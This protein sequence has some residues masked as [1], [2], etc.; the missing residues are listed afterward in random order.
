MD[1]VTRWLLGIV[2]IAL[3][4]GLLVIPTARAGDIG[5][6]EDFALARDRTTA[7]K[8]L[9]PGTE[10]YYYYHCLHYLNTEQYE[11]IDPLIGPWHQRHSQTARL[12]EIQTRLALLTYEK[13]PQKTLDYLRNRLGLRFDHQKETVGA[14]PDL[15]TV[16]D[17]KLISRETLKGSSLARW[18]NLDNFE[19][20][21]LDWMAAEKLGW[22]QMRNLISRLQRPDVADLPKLIAADLKAP[23][24]GEFGS[25]PIHA[26]LTLAQLDEVRKLKPD[27]LNQGAYVRTYITKLQPGADDDWKRDRKLTEAY[28]DRLEK[29]VDQLAPVHNA[30]K[31]HVLYHRLAFDRA[32]GV[33]DSARFLAY[34]Q[35][36]RFQPYMARAWNERPESGRHPADLNADF[37]S[38]TLLPI[39]GSDEPL[40]RTYLKHFFL[41]AASTKEYEPYIDDTYLRYLFAETKIETGQ[42]EPETWASG[43]PPELFRQ[44]KDRIDIDFAFTNKTDFTADEAVKLDLFIKNVPTLLVKVFEI[45]TRNL[46]RAHL[47][48]VDTD[49]NLDGLVANTE[50]VVK[51]DD[52]PFRRQARQFDFPELNKAGT[53][54]IDFIGGGKSSRALIRKGRLHSIVTTGI[55]GQ[56][57]RVIDERHRQVNDASVWLSGQEYKADKDGSITIPF[58]AEP[59]QR[60]IVI[61]RG[62]F[63][64][65]DH[66]AHQPE[67]Y[68][69]SAG[70][71]VDR[72]SLLTQRIAPVL[73]RA[74]LFLNDK[75]VSL[76][77][78][79]DVKLRITSIDN[80]D[81]PSSRTV[82]RFTRCAFP[83]G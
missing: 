7:L 25:F 58:T 45:N 51:Y 22:E 31:A 42:G 12:T 59:G 23:H 64:C 13:N 3:G 54:V 30:L 43:L 49:I 79:E 26:Q 74:G 70:I 47:V 29:F 81:I 36:P 9:I 44:L 78:L 5:Y 68:R 14:A 83:R 52:S 21:A 17:A 19:D 48:E 15:P 82:K 27:V 63:A 65:L 61:S 46:Y 38:I 69:L 71:H 28:L 11:K 24:S 20:A 6:V 37:S 75:P 39:V 34:V 60:A 56:T 40:V 76:N 2:L 57:I 55:A 72:E 41:A 4:A 73:V 32:R 1:R 18:G 66:V 35:L 50:H 67:T 8:Q 77:L 16:L 53:Y 80:S 62:D 33:Y 10:E